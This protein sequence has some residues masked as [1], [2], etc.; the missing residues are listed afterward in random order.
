MEQR[1]TDPAKNRLDTITFSRL[2]LALAA[3]YECLYVIDTENDHYVE[4]RTHGTDKRLVRRSSGDDFYADTVRNCRKLVYEED[5][6]EF[7]R[8]FSRENVM[9][10]LENGDS[11]SLNYRLVYDGKPQYYYLKTILGQGMDADCI[12]IG[13]QNV[14]AQVRR[15]MAQQAE[16]RTY[17]EIA[18]SLARLYEVIYHVDNTTGHYTAY[19]SS[20]DFT[21]REAAQDGT[22]FFGLMHT[23][24]RQRVHPDDRSMLMEKIEEGRLLLNLRETR[25][26]SLNYR[27][28]S[29]GVSEYV[30]LVAFLRNRDDGHFVVAIR[31]IDAQVRQQSEL[32]RERRIYSHIAGALAN[33]Y[34]V[35]YYIDIVTNA[36]IQYSASERF[37]SLGIT[38]QGDDFFRTAVEDIQRYIHPEDSPYLMSQ[39]HKDVLLGKLG[40]TGT[41]S[42]TYRQMLDGRP[43]YV[44][45][46][47][48]RPLNDTDHVVIGVLN[49]D[50]QIRREQ[51]MAEESAV[52]GTIARAL[53]QRYEVIYRINIHTNAYKEY[54]SSAKY[55]RLEVGTTGRDFFEDTQKNMKQDIYPEDYPMMA[56]AMRKDRLL[57]SMQETGSTALNYRLML[58]GKPQYVTLFAILPKEDADHIIVAVA[59]VDAA[60]RQELAFR[61]ALGSAMDMARRDALTGVKNKY[62]YVQAEAE[63]DEQ[64]S[65]GT[66]PPFAI[67]VFDVNGLKIVNDTLGHS[68]GDAYIREACALICT[69]FQHSPVFRIGGD[70]F[71]ALLTNRDYGGRDLL[72]RQFSDCID[73]N[74]RD[75]HVSVAFGIS[76][77]DAHTDLRVQDVFERADKAMYEHKK[78][79]K[80]RMN[81]RT[82]AP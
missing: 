14:D 75:G 61:E 1:R 52:F 3:D 8:V 5:Q 53:A 38:R 68:A 79:M 18:S 56:S 10:A 39:L 27:Q 67:M 49:V 72:I 15:E 23:L 81:A 34:E 54:S 59:N 44:T 25:V 22:D 36:Y 70:E 45:M 19:R 37:A 7:L 55:A 40:A 73:E 28:L 24:I 43:Q 77:Y 20:E 82:P 46:H 11:F 16:L 58:D 80:Q 13:V 6:E 26:I 2:A 42:M 71:V 69:T 50:A 51:T 41:S 4:Y 78:A 12:V 60:K 9:A 74:L 35:I 62:A 31:N 48:V 64:I 29:G 30:N 32:D 57:Q 76:E 17:T 47:V 65:D 63:L 21:R 66:N 33:R